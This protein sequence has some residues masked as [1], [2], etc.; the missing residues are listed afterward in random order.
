MFN[1]QGHNVLIHPLSG[2]EFDDHIANALW[3]GRP[4]PL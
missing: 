1:R 4:V 3:L 2:D